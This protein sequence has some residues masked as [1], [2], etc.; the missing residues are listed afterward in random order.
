MRARARTQRILFGTLSFK[1]DD[2]NDAGKCEPTYVSVRVFILCRSPSSSLAGTH[3]DTHAHTPASC[4]CCEDRGTVEWSIPFPSRELGPH[5]AS[6]KKI[7]HTHSSFFTLYNDDF[8]K[9]FVIRS[10]P[11][12]SSKKRLRG[13]VTMFHNNFSLNVSFSC[14]KEGHPIAMSRLD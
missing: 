11:H 6:Q 4:L 12:V 7:L 1:I 2:L 9:H 8:S 3:R 14:R 5:K 13:F 10:L